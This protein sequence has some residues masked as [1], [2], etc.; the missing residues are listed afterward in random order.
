M[1]YKEITQYDIEDFERDGF[2]IIKDKEFVRDYKL[3]NIQKNHHSNKDYSV[4]I[5]LDKAFTDLDSL[6]KSL[7]NLVSHSK[8]IQY[9]SIVFTVDDT[10]LR[11]MNNDEISEMLKTLTNYITK[12]NKVKLIS[13]GVTRNGATDDDVFHSY[14]EKTK[15]VMQNIAKLNLSDD[16]VLLDIDSIRNLLY[17]TDLNQIKKTCLLVE[18]DKIEDVRRKITQIADL[19]KSKTS[20]PYEQHLLALHYLAQYKYTLNDKKQPYNASRSLSEIVKNDAK[21]ICCVGYARYY[22]E[23][24]RALGFDA[25][26]Q[27]VQGHVRAKVLMKEDPKYGLKQGVY[28]VDPT[29]LSN[30]Q[31]R[32]G[33]SKSFNFNKLANLNLKSIV[34]EVNLRFECDKQISDAVRKKY[35]KDKTLYTQFKRNYK[36]FASMKLKD[37]S[38]WALAE[39]LETGAEFYNKISAYIDELDKHEQQK[40]VKT[41]TDILSFIEKIEPKE[42]TSNIDE[43]FSAFMSLT[44]SEKQQKM[45][46]FLDSVQDIIERECRVE[47]FRQINLLLY[48]EAQAF[49]IPKTVAGKAFLSNPISVFHLPRFTSEIDY[50]SRVSEATNGSIKNL[51]E[52]VS[53]F[54]KKSVNF[55]LNDCEYFDGF[56]RKTL[57]NLNLSGTLNQNFSSLSDEEFQQIYASTETIDED[58][59]NKA[60]GNIMALVKQDDYKLFIQNPHGKGINKDSAKGR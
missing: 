40:L 13:L 30:I 1:H 43:T 47:D 35:N 58:T 21:Y 22:T 36:K 39:Y 3:Y 33:S 26:S 28:V 16:V 31:E 54:A 14:N 5:S 57:E 29:W 51:F 53:N 34:D 27:T 15:Q 60:V 48:Q 8:D 10:T 38:N 42:P 18:N 12:Q 25:Q 32:K 45:Q 46:D 56:R 37:L 23:I 17:A 6:Y 11:Q 52:M 44:T 55:S 20:S 59:L 41:S 19:I 4:A 2:L 49:G 9:K 7:K 50:E 24:M